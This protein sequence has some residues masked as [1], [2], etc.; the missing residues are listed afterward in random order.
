[1]NID[2]INHYKI[3]IYE[4]YRNLINSGKDMHS[5]DNNDLWK[6][7]E[8]F[9][10]IK[11]SEERE[12]LFYEYND[13]DPNFKEI[14]KMSRNDT[15]ID[16]SDLLN[17]IV[18]CKLRKNS[19]TWRDCSTF[20]GSQVIYDKELKKPVV[21][22]ENLIITRNNDSILS[23]HLLERSELFIDKPYLR[24]EIISYCEGLMKNPPEYKI[25]KDEDEKEIILRDYQVE[26]I[27]LIHKSN[28]NSTICIPTGCGKNII[29]IYSM[30]DNID[31]K[32]LILVPRIILMEQFND[33][34]LLHKP[35]WK[36]DIQMIGDGNNEFNE[37]K[38]ITICVYNSVQLIMNYAN[39]FEKIYIDEAHH[40]EKP[41]IYKLDEDEFNNNYSY[42]DD[43]DEDDE[44]NG[45]F[46]ESEYS[47]LD[48]NDSNDELKKSNYIKF[49]RNLSKYKNNVYLSATIDH[50]EGFDFY[51]KDIRDMIEKDYLSDYTVHIPIFNDD[52]TN[53]NICE[54]VLNNYKNMIIYCN[55]QEEG[56]QINDLMNSIM[57]KSCE[58]LDCNT[59]KNKRNDIINRFKC[60]ELS[61]LVNV[62]I[63]IEGFNAPI[64]KGV[65][66]MHLPKTST[67][68]IQIIGRSLRLHS[69]KKYSNIILPYSCDEDGDNISNFLKVM[70]NN[71]KRIKK[72]YEK[73]ELGGYILF[74]MNEEDDGKESNKNIDCEEKTNIEFKFE[75]V[76]NSMGKIKNLEEIWNFKKNLLFEY[77]DVFGFCPKKREIYKDIKI[78]IFLQ[79]IKRN[80]YNNGKYNNYIYNLLSENVILKDNIDKYIENKELNKN[81]ND[82]KLSFDELFKILLEFIEKEGRCP[83]R[84]ESYNDIK[85]GQWL[86]NQKHKILDKDN[87]LYNILSLN[88]I[89]KNNLDKYL[90]EKDKNKT[91]V[92]ITQDFWYNLFF[93]F[94]ELKKRCPLRKEVYKEVNLGNWFHITTKEKITDI[95]SIEYIKLSKNIIVKEHLDDYLK[96]KNPNKKK[97][98][99]NE[100]HE[101]FLAFVEKEKRVPSKKD[102]FNDYK[103]GQSYQDLKKRLSCIN[104]KEYIALSVNTI[105]KDNLDKYIQEKNKK[106][107]K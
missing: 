68:L 96:I 1:M 13:I 86:S 8:Y 60:G 55:S 103:I 6:I 106:I 81:N 107:I 32:Y 99:K 30:F 35:G 49:I 67:T 88:E 39:N 33:E 83:H 3:Q 47:D 73:K 61:F 78:G 77:V 27:E 59:K 37:K 45:D 87:K 10:C 9:S 40:I 72:S 12:T 89:I 91:K 79:T 5:F 70:A 16:C 34:L 50:I 42:S 76:Y 22:W 54:Y 80:I 65:I 17:T 94:I 63:L 95:N 104:D 7:F 26:S 84:T 90:E 36:D 41:E 38:R 46:Y 52:P 21:R 69:D 92:K 4:R 97:L 75:M 2:I 93:E 31:K 23:E 101:L 53:R 66:F 82:V 85:I 98:K 18:Q 25:S 105:I 74:N 57:N 51:K 15:G 11:L 20:F 62:R 100:I 71:D 29:I 19:L 102:I 58:Y 43:D 24:G 44:D 64:T 14:N 56:R 48:D 28:K